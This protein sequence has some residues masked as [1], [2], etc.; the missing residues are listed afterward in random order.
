VKNILLS[1]LLLVTMLTLAMNV[2]EA[3][4]KAGSKQHAS[5]TVKAPDTDEPAEEA[6]PPPDTSWKGV[7][8]GIVV[9]VGAEG[10]AAKLNMQPA[11]FGVCA[12]LFLLALL[13]FIILLTMSKSRRSRVKRNAIYAGDYSNSIS[14]DRPARAEPKMASR[15][16]HKLAS[17]RAAS[18]TSA[19]SR[20]EVP[21]DFDL[22]KFL[23]S[24][25]S[26]FLR[27][28]NAWDQ[29]DLND[30]REFTNDE[31]H[32]EL[33]LQLRSR[34][35]NLNKTGIDKLDSKLLKLDSA[36][37]EYIAVVKFNGMIREESNPS[38]AFMEVWSVTRPKTGSRP[39]TVTAIQQF[40]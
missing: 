9:S 25:N 26:M 1:L 15:I 23:R 5:E 35:E 10:L 39:W 13:V 14:S 32:D 30:I 33:K 28:Q 38:K 19:K 36:G 16:K 24:A 40:L 3:K 31:I 18:A 4:P 11:T 34:G 29:G 21:A 17:E 2:V 7:V 22:A 27:L 20:V 8:A 6:P 37:K 12:V